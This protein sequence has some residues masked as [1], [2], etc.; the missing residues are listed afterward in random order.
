MKLEVFHVDAFAEQIFQGNPAAVCI[1]DQWLPDEIM[2]GIADELNLSE[3]AFCVKRGDGDYRIRWFTPTTEVKLCGHATLATAHILYSQKSYPSDS[4]IKFH[5]LGG[6][7]ITNRV[8]GGLSLI[9][10]TQHAIPIEKNDDIQSALR[11]NIKEL[12][13]GD[14]LVVVL[15]DASEVEIYEPD[16]SLIKKLPYRGVCITA[17]GNGNGFDFVSRFFAPQSGINEDPV[18]GSSFAMLAPIYALK[19]GKTTFRARQLSPRGGNVTL[20]LSDDGVTV[21]G[22]AITVMQS[23][24]Q[25]PSVSY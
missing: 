25:L 6:Q 20:T 18:T 17:P 4:S 1:L 9:L 14:D 12:Y 8:N 15:S 3:T 23:T 10:P 13:A 16:F 11:T 21:V 5:S 24:F 7:L 19:Q 22:N 2:Q